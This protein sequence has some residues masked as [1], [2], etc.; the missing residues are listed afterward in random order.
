MSKDSKEGRE[1]V[2]QTWDK[3]TAGRETSKDKVLRQVYASH[4]LRMTEKPNWL[5]TENEG[6]E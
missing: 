2:I 1:R 4:D 3:N 6:E 5:R